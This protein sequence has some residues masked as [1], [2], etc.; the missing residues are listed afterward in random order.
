MRKPLEKRIMQVSQ[1][2]AE[3]LIECALDFRHNTPQTHSLWD[4]VETLAPSLEDLDRDLERVIRKHGLNDTL[5]NRIRVQEST[6]AYTIG[7]I[8]GMHLAGRTDLIP[9]VA[10][11]YERNTIDGEMW[12]YD[13]NG[14]SILPAKH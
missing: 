8:A 2:I 11:L 10:D 13:D 9:K 12:D 5:L 14:D 4:A 7:I 1:M 3:N 6:T